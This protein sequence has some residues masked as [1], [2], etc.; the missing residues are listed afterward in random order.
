[1]GSAQ[2]ERSFLGSAWPLP[3]R[4][5]LGNACGF[6]F[7]GGASD[8]WAV[9]GK[10]LTHFHGPPQ[11][12]WPALWPLAQCLPALGLVPLLG[13]CTSQAERR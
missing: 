9:L 6:Q 3:P 1:M 2:Q 12:P 5:S 4:H 8:T 11:G 13:G 10:A 7:C